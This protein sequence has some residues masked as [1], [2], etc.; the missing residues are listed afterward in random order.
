MA[1]KQFPEW[2]KILYR[3]VRTAVA[4]GF[5]SAGALYAVLKPDWSNPDVAAKMVAIPLV[6]AFAAG[7]IVSFG[8]WLR[9]WLDSEMGFDEKS[10]IAK[11][12]PI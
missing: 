10:L 4:A 5:T 7:F 11:L 6:V 12:M 2:A 1:N 9:D 8:M 3:G